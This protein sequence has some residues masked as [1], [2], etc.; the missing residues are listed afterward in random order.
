MLLYHY[1][2]LRDMRYLCVWG[3]HVISLLMFPLCP[4][5]S[6][7]IVVIIIM[8]ILLGLEFGLS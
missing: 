3:M 1:D 8:A 2:A 5:S 7:V 4:S 6:S